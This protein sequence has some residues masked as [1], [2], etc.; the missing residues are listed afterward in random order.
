MQ[1]WGAGGAAR[2]QAAIGRNSKNTK[3][4]RD[5]LRP[6]EQRRPSGSCGIFHGIRCAGPPNASAT[7]WDGSAMLYLRRSVVLGRLPA[8]QLFPSCCSRCWLHAGE[9]CAGGRCSLARSAVPLP[10]YLTFSQ[11][12]LP[13]RHRT[14]DFVLLIAFAGV[15][16]GQNSHFS[17]GFLFVWRT[18]RLRARTPAKTE[19]DS[20]EWDCRALKARRVESI[21]PRRLLLSG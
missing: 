3:N 16:V 12:P 6:V 5:R 18:E 15:E 10:Y 9:T 17:S 4:R 13:A 8:L 2:I 14:R 19:T 1:A 7:S 20:A 21:S 11:V